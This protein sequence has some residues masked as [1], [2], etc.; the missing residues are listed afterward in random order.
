MYKI[1]NYSVLIIL[2]AIFGGCEPELKNSEEKLVDMIADFQIAKVALQRY[3]PDDRDSIYQVFTEEIFEIHKVAK[4]S[5]EYD[6]HQ[7]EKDPESYQA[8]MDKV[9]VKLNG[10]VSPDEEAV[11]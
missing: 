10:K 11:R 5:F 6:I 2:F 3:P 1:L 4:S 8:I 7:L 9:T